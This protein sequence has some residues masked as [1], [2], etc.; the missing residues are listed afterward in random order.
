[1]GEFCWTRSG[2]ALIGSPTEREPQNWESKRRLHVWQK[3][4]DLKCRDVLRSAL[5]A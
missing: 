2:R 3:A 4:V 5:T 1:M